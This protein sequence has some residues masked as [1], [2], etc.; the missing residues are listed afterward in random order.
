MASMRL[1]PTGP[2]TEYL[3]P[4]QSPNPKTASSGTPNSRVLAKALETAAKCFHPPSPPSAL[5]SHRFARRAFSIVSAVVKVFDATITN[6]LAGSSLESTSEAL[7]PSTFE[8]KWTR[9]LPAYGNKALHAISGPRCDPPIPI[10]TTSVKRSPVPDRRLPSR[11]S[12]LKQAIAS[13]VF[14]IPGLMSFP[15]TIR[16]GPS[17]FRRAVCR[18]ALPSVELIGSPSNIASRLPLTSAS[19][20]SA[21][22]ALRISSSIPVLE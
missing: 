12:A 21:M 1:S 19:R 17:G 13:K 7:A 6:V 8:M 4:T 16:G 10:F 9:S 5:C 11:I 14:R 15:S 22:R 20:A 2:Q 3:P 18:T